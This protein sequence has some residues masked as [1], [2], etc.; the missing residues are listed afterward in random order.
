MDKKFLKDV[1][2]R[3]FWTFV[4]AAI[5]AYTVTGGKDAAKAAAIAGAAAVLSLLKG[6]AASRIGVKDSASTIPSI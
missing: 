4:Q 6:I 3:A 1:A 2:E 5:A